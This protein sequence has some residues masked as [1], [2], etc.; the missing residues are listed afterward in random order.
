MKNAKSHLAICLSL[1]IIFLTFF[2]VFQNGTLALAPEEKQPPQKQTKTTKFFVLQQTGDITSGSQ[3]DRN[4]SV[5]LGEQD[6]VIKSALIELRGVK[7]NPGPGPAVVVSIDDAGLVLRQ[8]TYNLDAAGGVN[9]LRFFY[10]A[11][12]YLAGQITGTGNWNFTLS[13]KAV[14]LT[15]SALSARIYLNY[16]F[17]PPSEGG[18]TTGELISA[19]FETTATS[20]GPAYNSI[21]WKGSLGS[22]KVRLKLAT[23]DNPAG[24]WEFR[25]PEPNCSLLTNSDSDWYVVSANTPSEI[26]C[27]PYHNNKRY[28][29]YKIQLCMAQDCASQGA[30]SPGVDDVVVNWSP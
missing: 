17:A 10:D 24:P 4:F 14:D 18:A 29:K 28:F 19:V 7:T 1:G 5:Y 26:G 12:P 6:P 3:I 21:L 27:F 30:V 9:P 15:I 16:Q 11:T 22:G 20:A 25:G 2:L 23:S 8:K 13:V